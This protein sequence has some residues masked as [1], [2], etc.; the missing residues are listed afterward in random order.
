MMIMNIMMNNVHVTV[1]AME[2][3]SMAITV[4]IM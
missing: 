1:G 2:V 3:T 4:Y